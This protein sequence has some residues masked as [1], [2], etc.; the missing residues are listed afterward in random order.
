MFLVLHVLEILLK[1]EKRYFGNPFK[2][3]E[4]YFGNFFKLLK[5]QI[6]KHNV[7]L[8]DFGHTCIQGFS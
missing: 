6:W 3:D 4:R 7:F 8:S 1:M 5:V 2:M